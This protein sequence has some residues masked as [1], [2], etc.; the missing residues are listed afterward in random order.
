MVRPY[1]LKPKEVRLELLMKQVARLEKGQDKKLEK[2]K[3]LRN[4]A[5]AL[6][7]V[8]TK[9]QEFKPLNVREKPTEEVHG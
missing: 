2:I 7:D 1:T 6:Q 8:I 5:Q 4:K 9:S 3:T